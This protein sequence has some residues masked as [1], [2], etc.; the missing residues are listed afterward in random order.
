VYSLLL[1]KLVIKNYKSLHDLSIQLKK[2][3]VLIGRNNT[4]KSNILDCLQFVSDITTD[5]IDRVFAAR[6]DFS[7]VVYGGNPREEISMKI[8]L[9]I[10]KHKVCYEITLIDLRVLREKVFDETRS[11]VLLSRDEKGQIIFF[12][13]GEQKTFN[14]GVAPTITALMFIRTDPAT[15]KKCPTTSDLVAFLKNWKF[16]KLNPSALRKALDPR[17]EYDIGKDGGDMAL[18]LH[19][20]VSAKLSTFREVEETLR[21]AIEEVEELQSPLTDDGRTYVAVKERCFE[22][23]FDHY[24]LS[25]GILI[26]LAHLLVVFSP[27]KGKL[28]GIEEPEDYVHPKLLKFLV[29]TVK[30]SG[31]QV[32]LVTHSPYLLDVVSPEDVFI[33]QKKDGNTVCKSPNRKE[34]VK[35]LK[36]FSLGELWVS[37]ELDNAE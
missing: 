34:L 36:E 7:H 18:V 11:L 19:T 20:L 24:Q 30:A 22:K 31:T 23:P 12:D 15:E 9:A 16:Y 25:D 6:G 27:T 28:I 17:K 10:D 8:W 2:F 32:M 37:G 3:N 35:F 5:P 1:E 21:S 33:V 26:L 14:V 4:G 29:D 13:E